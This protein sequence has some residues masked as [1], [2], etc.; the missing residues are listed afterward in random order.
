MRSN[1]KVTDRLFGEGILVEDYLVFIYIII[2][3][4]ELI[5]LGLL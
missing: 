2:L 4:M 5:F 3:C 1:V